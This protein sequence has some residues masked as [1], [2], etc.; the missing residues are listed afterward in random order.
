[1]A[2]K[3][4]DKKTGKKT[5]A[6]RG[7]PP[8]K[9]SDKNKDRLTPQQE[10]FCIYIA[11]GMTQRAAYRAAY[12]N[13]KS[14]D[15]VIDVKASE[16]M[17]NG[18]VVVRLEDLLDDVRRKRYKEAVIKSPTIEQELYR[19]GTGEKEIEITGRDGK[20]VKVKPNFSDRVRALGKLHEVYNEIMTNEEYKTVNK[21]ENQVIINI[22][23]FETE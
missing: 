16:L 17:R 5:A 20:T 19:I 8:G 18:K 10:A 6:R 13:N 12:P 2:K 14:K 15:S 1:M 11:G 21:S 7:R 23:P 9:K 4:T 3:G 22:L